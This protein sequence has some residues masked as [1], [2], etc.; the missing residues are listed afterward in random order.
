[1]SAPDN[2]LIA[3]TLLFA[4]GFKCAKKLAGKITAIFLLCKQMLS[5][6]IHYDWGLRALKT[7]LL[8]SGNFISEEL[9]KNDT[10]TPTQEAEI[11]IK[12]LCVNTT[13][14]LT[15][16]D[17][18]KFN[19]IIVDVMPE[20]QIVEF[21]NDRLSKAIEQ[22]LLEMKLDSLPRQKMKVLQLYEA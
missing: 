7:I 17:L 16:E 6:Q 10:L 9:Q 2:E 15:F 19:S 4:E 1:M 12:A 14:K 5:L 22:T 13:S 21:T 8:A 18:V 3:Q 11:M 20:T